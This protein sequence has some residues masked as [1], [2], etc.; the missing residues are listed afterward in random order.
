MVVVVIAGGDKALR[1]AA[2]GVEDDKAAGEKDL[3][4]Y[5]PGALDSVVGISVAGSAN[6]VIGALEYAKACGALTVALTCNA[7]RPLEKL[8]DIAIT[9]DTGA[10]VI[11]G[12]TRMKAGSAHKMVLNMLS[13]GVLIKYG[14][15]YQNYMIYIKPVNGKLRGRMVRMTAEIFGTDLDNAERRHIAHHWDLHKVLD[16]SES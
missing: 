1:N 14:R 8:A 11:T 9:T 12:S 6:Y 10:E 16:T 4:A 13:T 2:E 3:A 7:D 15:V 5:A